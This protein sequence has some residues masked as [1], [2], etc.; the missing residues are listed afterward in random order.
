MSKYK[1]S[2]PTNQKISSQSQDQQ[3]SKEDL[4]AFTG[5]FALLLEMEIDQKNNVTKEHADEDAHK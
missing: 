5:L 3:L 2:E 1:G 4:N